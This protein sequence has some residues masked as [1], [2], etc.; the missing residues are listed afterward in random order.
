MYSNVS[1]KTLLKQSPRT[2]QFFTTLQKVES[3]TWDKCLKASGVTKGY[4]QK[5]TAHGLQ[6]EELERV[7]AQ[8]YSD[9]ANFK[10]MDA[11]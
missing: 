6:G 7:V 11:A 3:T 8:V 1:F 5:S 10:P 4:F 9:E 2:V